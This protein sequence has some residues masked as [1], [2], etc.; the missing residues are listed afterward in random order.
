MSN[1]RT[2]MHRLQELVRLHR[3]MKNQ[4]REVARLLTMSPNTERR[5]RLALEEANLLYGDPTE[6]PDLEILKA[7]IEKHC[8]LKEPPQ[9][10]STIQIWAEEV[11]DLINKGLTPRAIYDRL[12]QQAAGEGQEG[13]RFTGSY[14]AVKRLYKRIRRAKGIQAKDVAIPVE[15]GPGEIAQVD[16][17]YVGYLYDQDQQKMRRAWV[18]VMVLGFSRHMVVRI[19]FDQKIE[20]WLNVHIE[21]LQE[22]GG[23]VKTVVPDNLKAA[24][25]RAAFGVDG[26]TALNRSY[27]ELARHYGFKIDPAPPYQAKKKGKVESGVKYAKNNFFKGRDGEEVNQVRQDLVRWVSE[28]AG[29]RNH[30]TTGKQPIE[31]FHQEEKSQLL[32]LPRVPFEQVVWKEALVHQDTH[33]MFEGRIYSVPWR[34]VGQQ[35]WIR[36]TPTTVV[37]YANDERVATHDRHGPGTRSTIE[38]HL[39][40]YRR[41][42]RH[43]S[44]EYWE[45]RASAMG[46]NVGQFIRDVFASDPVYSQLRKVQAIVMLLERYPQERA[47]AACRRAQFYGN[48]SYLSMKTMLVRGLDREPLPLVQGTATTLEQPRFARSLNEILERHWEGNHEPN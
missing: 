23:V 48:Q 19:V 4:C 31:V 35:V 25:I 3:M 26:P 8:P 34:W 13:S 45:Q 44:P 22:L 41:D 10:T 17:G 21:A 18:F 2:D 12:R 14:W 11:E 40:E 29:M 7:A 9:E 20:T 6:I 24:V 16:F 33:V 5:Y 43:R 39:P 47:Q 38:E 30:G 1:G 46:E 42:L 37:I 28:V 15:T 32:S 27:R 36:A